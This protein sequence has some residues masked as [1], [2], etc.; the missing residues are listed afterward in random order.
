[1][2]SVSLNKSYYF[3]GKDNFFNVFVHFD[4]SFEDYDAFYYCYKNNI[5][6]Y[7]KENK[8]IEQD[9]GQADRFTYVFRIIELDILLAKGKL[10]NEI[11]LYHETYEEIE[12][13]VFSDKE[14]I[15]IN[16][17]DEVNPITL[18]EVET[19]KEIKKVKELSFYYLREIKPSKI[20]G[21]IVYLGKVKEIE[22]EI[23]Y[24]NLGKMN[25]E[26]VQFLD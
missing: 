6:F 21:E 25:S 23:Y 3:I 11:Q 20:D 17:K 13:P 22:G 7:V 1:M 8:I 18:F 2:N 5:R 14:N 4:D 19:L 16:Y 26:L 12:F 10:K 9:E 15:A 24:V